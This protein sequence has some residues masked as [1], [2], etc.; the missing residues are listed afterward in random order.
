MNTADH[1]DRLFRAGRSLGAWAT[2]TFLVR[3]TI[4]HHLSRSRPEK[5]LNVFLRIHLRF[6]RAC[7]LA[8]GRTSFASSRTAKSDRL[9]AAWAV[10]GL[11]VMLSF[12][13][14]NVSES[15]A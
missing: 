7:G 9:L 13:T 3:R 15:S 11:V 4:R 2:L 12:C 6:F 14:L 10:L 1:I 8:S 5:I